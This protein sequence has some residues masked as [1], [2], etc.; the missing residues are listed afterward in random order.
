MKRKYRKLT[1]EE[2]ERIIHDIKR[3]GV[4]AGCRKHQLDATTYYNWLDRYE[5]GGISGLKDRR[6]VSSEANLKKRDKEIRLLK[7][8]IAEKEMTIK[9]QQDIIEKKYKAWK[10]KEY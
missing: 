6:G 3:I 1:P 2:K 10:R 4:V 5:A 8:I 9:L 7:E